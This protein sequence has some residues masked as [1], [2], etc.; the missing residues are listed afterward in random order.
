VNAFADTVA[1]KYPMYVVRAL[2]GLMFLGG[3]LIMSYNLWMT[4]KAQ[5]AKAPL[6]AN[7]AVPAE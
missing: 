1:A 3:A 4:V 5:P 7:N 2:G 6:N